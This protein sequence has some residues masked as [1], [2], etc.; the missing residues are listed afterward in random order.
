MTTPSPDEEVPSF[1]YLLE[2]DSDETFARINADL[3]VRFVV[4]VV[5]VVIFEA[6]AIIFEF[7]VDD[8]DRYSIRVV[9][10]GETYANSIEE[11]SCFI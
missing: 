7:D 8:D 9:E 5:V 1:D 11:I 2:E 3:D 6:V 10:K 4:V